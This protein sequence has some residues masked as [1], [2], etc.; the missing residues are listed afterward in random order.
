MDDLYREIE[1]DFP[2]LNRTVHGDTPLVYL[3]SA[4]TS[5]TPDPVLDSYRAYYREF[6]ANVHRGIHALSEEATDA[7]E[8]SRRKVAQFINAGNPDSVIFTKSTTEGINLVSRA[9]GDAHV[10]SGDEIL[11]TVM[12]HH[13]NMVPWKQLADRTGASLRYVDINDDG[14]LRMDQLKELLSENTR[15]VALSHA[16]NVLGTVNPI[17]E[18][19][20]RAHDKDVPVLVDGAQAIP[21][22][23]V[24]VRE[25]GVDFYAFS[26]H[27]MLGPTG[28]G[29][30]YVREGILNDMEPFLGGG[31]M[32][33]QVHLDRIEYDTPPQKFEA[34]TPNIAQAIGLGAAIDYL[35]NIGMNRIH[36]REREIVGKA[37]N[38]LKDIEGVRLY[39]P[40]DRT[41]LIS[42]TLDDI[43]PHDI[44]TIVDR[45]GV[46]IRAG[47]H[48]AQPLMDRF[49]I[50]ATARASFYLY[51]RPQDV[52][53]LVKAIEKARELFTRNV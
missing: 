31:E 30:L 27:K 42:F 34:G 18:V 51:N 23:P 22:L 8:E 44:S 17:Q 37:Y 25:L 14:T 19:I 29:A 45:E 10:K 47:H 6:N 43:H 20:E 16:S 3:D 24:D 33:R 52:D 12:E 2:I 36:A 15:L 50:S 9:W 48:C 38:R 53:A 13:S 49:D 4:A 41:G 7:Y 21:H 39:G 11:L 28:V 46:A 26:G 32:I 1:D 35:E 5:L 40:E